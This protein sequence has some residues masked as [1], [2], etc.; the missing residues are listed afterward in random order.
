IDSGMAESIEIVPESHRQRQLRCDIT[1]FPTGC[2]LRTVDL[3]TEQALIAARGE[4]QA[5]DAAS[6]AAG[7]I[8]VRLSVRGHVSAASDGLAALTGIARDSLAGARFASL[9]T[10][11][12]RVE[13]AEAIEAVA[14][15][16]S[17]RRIAAECLVHGANPLPVTIGIAAVTIAG[18]IETLIAMIVHGFDPADA[19]RPA[20][21]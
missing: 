17:Q 2:L 18:R 9:F 14:S 5:A 3:T 6:A 8:C 12:S 21:A 16:A 4:L 20:S 7:A 13:V 15:G 19:E 10:V 1:A 11:A